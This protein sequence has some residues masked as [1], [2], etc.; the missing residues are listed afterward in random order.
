MKRVPSLWVLL[1]CPLLAAAAGPEKLR[2]IEGV[3]EY[4]LDNGLRV[5]LYPDESTPKLNI[6]LTVFV[7]SRH[8]GYGETGM[9]H[10]LE[11]MMFKGTPTHPDVPAALRDRGADWNANTWYDRTIY[12]ETLRA[13]DAN[14]EFGLRLEADRLVNSLIRREDLISEMTVVRN[15]FEAGENSPDMILSQRLW[16]VAFEW[17]NYGKSTI[18]NRSDIE[19]VPID[20]LQAFYKKYYRPDNAMVVLSGNFNEARALTLIAKYFG[21]LKKPAHRLDETYTEEPAQDGER[22]VVLRRVGKVGLASVLYH[23]PAR[24]DADFAPL[25]ILT[26]ILTAEPSGRLYQALVATK[27]ASRVSGSALGLHDPGGLEL[28]AEVGDPAQLEP[29]REVLLETAEKLAQEKPTRQELDRARRKLLK[30]RLLLMNDPTQVSQALSEWAAS[31]DWRLFFL[32]RDRLAKVTAEDVQ[33]VAGRYLLRSNRTVGL[34]IPTDRPQRAPVP[35]RPDVEALVKDYQGGKAIARGEPFEPTVENVE[36]RT[37][38]QQLPSGLRTALLAKKTRAEAVVG[39][40]TLRYGN[41][42]S[43][44]GYQTAGSLL[45]HLLLRGTNKKTREQLEDEQDHLQAILA[46]TGERGRLSVAFEC[47][48]DTL[49]AVLRLVGEVLRQPALD[50]TEF[51]LLKRETRDEWKKGLTDPATLAE[52]A[53]RRKLRPYPADDVRYV[54][55]REEA[56]ARLEAVT[57]E[58][59]RKLYQEQLGVQ[60]GELVLV[61]DFDAEPALALVQEALKDWKTMVPFRRIVGSTP[62]ALKGSR[63][64]IEVAD[65]E[66]A[67]YDAGLPVALNDSDPDY[68]GLSVAS[69]IFGEAPLSSRLARRIRQNEGLSYDCGCSLTIGWKERDG[70][71]TLNATCNPEN[72]DKVDKGMREELDRLVQKGLDAR[73]VEEGKAAYL[74]QLRSQRIS[75]TGLV[76]LLAGELRAE[77]TFAYYA[78][79]EKKIAALTPEAVNAAVRQHLNPRQLVIIQAGDFSKNP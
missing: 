59:V 75:D 55:T 57:V 67:V 62:A 63:E 42:Q 27:K 34:F 41:E 11:H 37:R 29:V 47:R 79:L 25:D 78:D 20:R 46:V 76:S 9:A 31:G 58:Q 44:K 5:L 30:E 10:L 54:P 18:G 60:A 6:N 26:Q 51:D 40:L 12:Y 1:V 2:T 61:G 71:L 28:S 8:E 66:N 21:P 14:L 36:K 23:I 69:F 4:L 64:R 50:A 13:S 7:G 35:P 48:R 74:E 17:H 70:L 38:Y 52:T 32:H 19:R 15:E 77:R 73:E 3:S 53:L 16:A 45:P 49:P 56:L 24:S 72:I 33:R 68:P 22:A 39:Q 65:K 43:L